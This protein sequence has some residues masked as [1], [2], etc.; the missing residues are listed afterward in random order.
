MTG[1]QRFFVAWGQVWRTKMREAA[2][3]SQVNTG[4]HSP[5]MYRAFAPLR[6]VDS[7][8]TAFNV[9]PGEKLYIAP[10]KRARLW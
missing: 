6:N 3:R 7:W 10:E 4:P 8:Y 5:G 2:L 1:E 9:Q